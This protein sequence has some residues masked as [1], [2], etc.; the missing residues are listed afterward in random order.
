MIRAVLF[1]LFG[2]LVESGSMSDR[3]SVS[4]QVA[5]ELCVDGQAFAEL[6]R[7][8]F[9]SRMKGELGGLTDTYVELARRLGG[10]PQPKQVDRAIEIRLN[11][12]R[13]LLGDTSAAPVLDHL[14][15]VGFRLGVVSDCSIETPTI[16]D[17]TWLSSLLDA[18]SF[19]CQLGVRKPHPEMYLEATRTL[20]VSP[21]ECLYV[22]D[23]GS[24]EL[25]GAKALGMHAV[26]VADPRED[27]RERPDEEI[28][29]TGDRISSL[30]EI[31]SLLGI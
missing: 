29:W 31:S 2:T 18:I 5:A 23:G 10:S 28:D 26:L 20:G 19:S 13:Q 25:S 9:D 30:S 1:D 11:F 4:H 15:S 14:R 7:S 17:A 3:E 21:G 12:S 22:G 8:T 24:H 27:G 6:V 16:W